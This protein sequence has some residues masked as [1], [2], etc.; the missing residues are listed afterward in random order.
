MNKPSGVRS[1]E[2]RILRVQ[3][4]MRF[5]P[6]ESPANTIRLPGHRLHEKF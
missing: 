5:A 1:P 6:A 2:D 3:P 4:A